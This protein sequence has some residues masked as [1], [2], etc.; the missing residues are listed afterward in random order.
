MN[1]LKLLALAGVLASTAAW[2]QTETEVPVVKNPPPTLTAVQPVN[3]VSA[4][5]GGPVI[6][7]ISAHV[8]DVGPLGVV[9]TI[10]PEFHFIAPKGNAVLLHRELV[11][12]SAN[13]LHLDTSSVIN[14][15]ADAQKKGAVFSG[16]WNC[17]TN[18]Y[19]VTLKVW[20]MDADGDRSNEAQFTVHCNGG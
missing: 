5:P 6:Q 7:S 19:Y 2:A 15:P 17:G 1:E 9:R 13:N 14:I 3:P 20:I 12:T 4:S 18:P 10:S 8:P 16:G 11:S